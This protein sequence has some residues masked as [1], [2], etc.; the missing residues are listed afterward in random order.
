MKFKPGNIEFASTSC[1]WLV[2]SGATGQLKCTGTIN[3]SGTYTML[4]SGNDGG[5]TGGSDR[6]RI[7][8]TN[9]TGVV[10]YDTQ[11]GAADTAT[12][13]TPTSGGSITVHS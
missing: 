10:V 4:V 1:Q 11:S 5:Q 12:P 7:K 2:V 13:T 8:I 6:L 9:S 3:G